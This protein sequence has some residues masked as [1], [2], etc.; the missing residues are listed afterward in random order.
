[1]NYRREIDGLRALAVVPVILYHA[2]LPYF[3]GGYVGVDVFFVISGFLI[4][5]IIVAESEAGNFSIARFYERRARR[6]LPALFVVLVSSIPLAIYLMPPQ[7]L[8]EFSDSLVATILFSSNFLFWQES[9][10]FGGEAVSKPLLHTWSLAIEEQYYLLFPILFSLCWRFGK[11]KIFIGIFFVALSSIATSTL[12]FAPDSEANFYLM[13]SRAWELLA[14]S[15]L[16]LLESRKPLRMRIKTSFA[17]LLS[18]LGLFMIVYAITMYSERTPFSGLSV[19]LPVTG[20][21]I[22]LAFASPDTLVGRILSRR[23]MVAVG[24][25]SYSAYLW[26]Q[27]LF[28]FARM[29]EINTLSMPHYG[30]LIIGTFFLA[31]ISWRYVELPFRHRNQ[32]ALNQILKYGSTAAISIFALGLVGS[33]SQLGELR[34]SQEELA[35]IKPVGSNDAD[36]EWRSPLTVFPKVETCEI[37]ANDNSAPIVFWGDSHV[38]ALISAAD[39]RF[40]EIGVSGLRVRNGYCQP[41]AGIYLAQ[42]FSRKKMEL[43][44]KSQQA[45]LELI[46][47]YKPRAIVIAMRWTFRLFPMQGI[48]DSLGFDNGEGGEEKES[49]RVYAAADSFGQLHSGYGAKAASVRSLIESFSTLGVPVLI[50]YPVPEVG[51]NL[52]NL[53]FKSINFG[54]GIQREVSTDAARFKA[55]NSFVIDLLDSIAKELNIIPIRVSE[56]LCDS[57]IVGRC[58]AQVGG[59]PLYFDDDH[60]S[61]VGAKLVIERILN[62]INRLGK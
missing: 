22:L 23:E 52:P 53:N 31:Y 21:W 59:I 40:E 33:Y 39:E 20:A 32:I 60:L 18:L 24:L 42:K 57:Y 51:W 3:G 27:P 2:G 19:L 10:Y 17:Q 30:A 54:N 49:Y 8:E 29:H 36:C 6:I 26:H 15:L 9:G 12:V 44:E 5:S 37:G 14:G 50:Q 7:Q 16:A 28:A 55:R 11:Q 58:V 43:C 1:M 38:D 41:I 13:P 35:A 56:I 25:V 4:T 48:V 47:S 61:K 62:E 46:S 34:Y 45:T